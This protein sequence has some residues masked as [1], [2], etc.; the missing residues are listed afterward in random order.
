MIKIKKIEINAN[1]FSYIYNIRFNK[2][3]LKNFL[4]K[5]KYTKDNFKKWIFLNKRYFFFFD[6]VYKNI[7]IGIIYYNKKSYKYFIYI[8]K[9]Y[10][11]KGLGYLSLKKFFKVLKNKK[12]KTDIL[13]KNLKSI[14]LHSKLKPKK[15]INK[16]KNYVFI[17]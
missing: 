14:Y 4:V 1:N 9:K 12:I 10:R 8:H 2:D 16:K 17:F 15:I 7:K 6:I 3:L 13:K 5:K 11:D